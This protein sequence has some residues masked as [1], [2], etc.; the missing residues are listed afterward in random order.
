MKQLLNDRIVVYEVTALDTLDASSATFTRQ[1][2]RV[3]IW[4]GPALIEEAA[5]GGEGPA[6]LNAAESR[7]NIHVGPFAAP[8][9][10]RGDLVT[11]VD[12]DEET[13]TEMEILERLP[14]GNNLLRT[15]TARLYQPTESRTS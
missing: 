1:D 3:Q 4:Q 13:L 5:G 11:K 6:N 10:R 14:I 2:T 8:L 12:G 9:F 7:V 15:Y